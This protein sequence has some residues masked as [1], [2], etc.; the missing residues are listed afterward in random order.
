MGEITIKHLIFPTK[1]RQ[2]L[3]TLASVSGSHDQSELTC[4]MKTICHQAYL[5]SLF[6]SITTVIEIY[7]FFIIFM[8]TQLL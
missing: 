5:I 7:M 1:P 3:K 4:E 6:I 8:D 2:V